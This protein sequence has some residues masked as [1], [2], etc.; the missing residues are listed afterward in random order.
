MYCV[1]WLSHIIRLL[2]KS[3]RQILNKKLLNIEKKLRKKNLDLNILL[4]VDVKITKL[5]TS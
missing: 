4:N 5:I 2:Q 3:R 1:R